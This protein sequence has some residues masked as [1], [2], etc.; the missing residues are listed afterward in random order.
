[1]AFVGFLVGALIIMVFGNMLND[2]LYS[3]LPDLKGLVYIISSLRF[4]IAF[5]LLVLF[6]T[7]MFKSLPSGKQ[8]FSDQLPGAVIT[9][10]GWVSFS[11]LFSFFVDNFSNYAN[12]YGSLTAIIVL[13]LWLYVCMYIMFIGAEINL[14]L[15]ANTK[16]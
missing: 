7:V 1:M 5:V 8:R 16:N 12:I 9:S 13:L 14:I 6:F 11:I 2:M 4:I 10:A 15:S 3:L